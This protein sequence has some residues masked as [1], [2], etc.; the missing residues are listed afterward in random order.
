[1]SAEVYTEDKSTV[2]TVN[3]SET[4]GEGSL[5]HLPLL[6]FVLAGQILPMY[7]IW[8]LM[9][10]GC[11]AVLVFR[12][13]KFRFRLMP[14]CLFLA[15]IL[16][17]GIVGGIAGLQ[18]GTAALWPVLRDMILVTYFPFCW[19]FCTQFSDRLADDRK[20]FIYTLFV[21]CGIVC[22]VCSV[23]KGVA[24]LIR[25]ES[26]KAVRHTAFFDEIIAAFGFVFSFF[27][28]DELKKRMSG[29]WSWLLKI[30]I[31]AA[32][33]LTMS[34]MIFLYIVCLSIPFLK[35]ENIGKIAGLLTAVA[36]MVALLYVIVPE[37]VGTFFTKVLNSFNEMASTN[38]TWT[39]MEIIRNWR[40]YEIACAKE[41]FS[42]FSPL[43]KIFG[44]G[45]GAT[46]DVH[47]YAYLVTSEA[48]IPFLHSGYYTTL[49]K[50]GIVGI[51]SM[52]L[53]FAS[54]MAGALRARRDYDR[55]LLA[56][57]V[58]GLAVSCVAVSG[59]LWRILNIMTVVLFAVLTED[60]DKAAQKAAPAETAKGEADA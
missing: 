8:M 53:M 58:L 36:G 55:R 17:L 6:L 33:V 52:L 47:G 38:K 43:Q 24:L 12:G 54:Q 25:N 50:A 15:V 13:E 29:F 27:P 41:K 32:I 16:F 2:Q 28:P 51:V 39:R 30:F 5:I 37:Q 3:G 56:G 4:G 46:V 48:S 20:R 60:T 11:L 42:A 57:L 40:G 44:G 31:L 18:N 1:M 21:A 26:F 49:I 7:A 45:F 34:R 59:L 19:L 10:V 14:G 23:E 35:K 9:V 22:L